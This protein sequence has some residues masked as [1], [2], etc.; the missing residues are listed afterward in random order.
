M[1]PSLPTRDEAASY[2]DSS[3]T[4]FSNRIDA[5]GCRR[6]SPMLESHGST[7]TLSPPSCCRRHFPSRQLRI[8]CK[9]HAT[10][11]DTQSPGLIT[12]RHYRGLANPA[13]LL[14]RAQFMIVSTIRRACVVVYAIG[15]ILFCR[16]F[17]SVTTKPHIAGTDR[18]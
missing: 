17:L 2:C 3:K 16:A 4:T 10:N 13:P 7:I 11:H 14:F 12:F 9:L 6:Q 18:L 1:I 15:L 5:V 8:T